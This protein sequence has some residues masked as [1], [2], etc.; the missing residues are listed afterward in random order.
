MGKDVTDKSDE[1]KVSDESAEA[2]SEAQSV[3]EENRRLFELVERL[4]ATQESEQQHRKIIETELQQMKLALVEQSSSPSGDTAAADGS[5]DLQKTLKALAEDLGT[6]LEKKLLA[7][8]GDLERKVEALAGSG[9]HAGVTAGSD[10]E[11]SNAVVNATWKMIAPLGDELER[12]SGMM[13]DL[14]QRIDKF[15]EDAEGAKEEHGGE[16]SDSEAFEGLDERIQEIGQSLKA[17]MKRQDEAQAQTSTLLSGLLETQMERLSR[18]WAGQIAGFQRSVDDLLLDRT[19]RTSLPD[20][21]LRTQKPS[22]GALSPGQ[23]APATEPEDATQNVV[24]GDFPAFPSADRAL[25]KPQAAGEAER[26]ELS[27][28]LK[29]E[30]LAMEASSDTIPTDPILDKAADPET[31][32]ADLAVEDP[33]E[34]DGKDA[35]LTEPAEWRTEET[36][37]E[38]AILLTHPILPEASEQSPGDKLEEEKSSATDDKQVKLANE[39]AAATSGRREIDLRAFKDL[40]VSGEPGDKPAEPLETLPKMAR[41]ETYEN[42]P[43]EASLTRFVRLIRARKRSS[44]SS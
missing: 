26:P 25:S 13:Q 10:N 40:R 35:L 3:K 22:N 14:G 20:E 38:E 15:A 27:P 28:D 7:T 44:S 8:M 36:A 4:I 2:Q 31:A 24:S 21:S 9:D 5:A 33:E 34:N 18:E 12:L 37:E 23:E 39:A 30:M 43:A 6:G 16:R 29:R 32:D 17:A 1:T 42:A 41:D 19:S 11:L